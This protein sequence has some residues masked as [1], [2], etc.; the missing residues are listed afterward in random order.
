[1]RF[2]LKPRASSAGLKAVLVGLCVAALGVIGVVLF[3]LQER[4]DVV[5][6]QQGQLD[7]ASV[8][9]VAGASPSASTALATAPAGER[10]SVPALSNLELDSILL[11]MERCS[12]GVAIVE[13]IQVV[14]VEWRA[15][16]KI[17]ME[18]NQNEAQLM[19]CL[20]LGEERPF[21]TVT[22]IAG[23]ELKVRWIGDRGER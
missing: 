3:T 16:L 18:A 20:T 2:E 7:A 15:D 17:L 13:Q 8:S 11:S 1:M 5:L 12:D 10:Y 19:N 21:W 6:E 4:I 22:E 23:R 14:Q 9:Q